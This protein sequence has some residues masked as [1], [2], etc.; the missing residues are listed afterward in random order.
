MG[1]TE[2]EKSWELEKGMRERSEPVGERTGEQREKWLC[3]KGGG[4]SVM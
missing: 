2:G 4:G 1:Q 3:Q